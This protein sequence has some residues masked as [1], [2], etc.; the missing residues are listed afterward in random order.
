METIQT[1]RERET[2]RRF[3]NG[4]TNEQLL[5]LLEAGT[6]APNHL[7]REPWRFL[8]INT[9]AGYEQFYANYKA[10]G[11]EEMMP[12]VWRTP[13]ANYPTMVVVIM[14]KHGSDK[15]QR[16]DLLAHGSLIQ[17][18]QLAAWDQGIGVVWKTNFFRP[19]FGELFGIQAHEEVT[20]YL[21]MGE[22][23]AAIQ[24]EDRTRLPLSDVMTILGE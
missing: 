23:E 13:G 18:I 20:G 2:I 1:I 9:P 5:P 14:P 21:L 4:I 16:E 11:V 17:N 6:W 22:F 12:P 3:K 8:V 19:G 7:H 15:E 24:A 10:F